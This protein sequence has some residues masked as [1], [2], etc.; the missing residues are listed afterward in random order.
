MCSGSSVCRAVVYEN[1]P[2]LDEDTLRQLLADAR[3]GS[4]SAADGT[5]TE[6]QQLDAQG[7]LF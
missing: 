2:R 3:H 5:S 1:A 6:L 4:A 7:L